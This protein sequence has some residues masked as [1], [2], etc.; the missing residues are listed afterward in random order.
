MEKQA[1][2]SDRRELLAQHLGDTQTWA[3]EDEHRHA[4]EW[5]DRIINLMEGNDPL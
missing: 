3:T 4:L 5:A 1:T 2:M